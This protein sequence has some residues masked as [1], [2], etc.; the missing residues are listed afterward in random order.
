MST[1]QMTVALVNRFL[2]E[3]CPPQFYCQD[4]LK[5][6]L[7]V[8]RQNT[9]TSATS[10]EQSSNTDGSIVSWKEPQVNVYDGAT[11]P[12]YDFVTVASH[13]TII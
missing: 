2:D 13:M 3:K 9:G 1:F 4:I 8:T 5:R 10:S 6:Y 7:G 11:V 12:Y